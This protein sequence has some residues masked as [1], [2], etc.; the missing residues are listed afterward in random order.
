[1]TVFG[2]CARRCGVSSFTAS[3]EDDP[4]SAAGVAVSVFLQAIR[5]RMRRSNSGRRFV[6]D[7]DSIGF[8]AP[9]RDCAKFSPVI[10][11]CPACHSKYQYDEERFERKPAKK[12]KCARCANVFEIQNPAFAPKAAPVTPPG[13]R[14]FSGKTERPA[15]P[16]E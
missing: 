7:A 11:E 16:S 6:I 8:A 13:D 1:M 2:S 10:I 3:F 12:I 15:T 14:T 9:D 4:V 5:G